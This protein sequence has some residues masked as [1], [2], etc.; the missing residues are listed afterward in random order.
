MKKIIVSDVTLRM[1]CETLKKALSFRERLNIATGLEKAGVD[2]VELP[3]IQGG[4]EDQVVY[5][6]I[7]NTLKCGVAIPVGDSAAS[8]EEAWQ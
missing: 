6:T 2:V 4:K 8:V 1:E 7:A 5:R 3:A